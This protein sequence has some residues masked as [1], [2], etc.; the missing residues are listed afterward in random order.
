[1]TAEQR[2]KLE[3]ARDMLYAILQEEYDAVLDCAVGL[4]EEVLTE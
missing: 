2:E 1:M 4:L 3:Q